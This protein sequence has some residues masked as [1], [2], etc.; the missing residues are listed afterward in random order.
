MALTNRV[1]YVALC[2]TH[3]CTHTLTD[4]VKYYYSISKR[5]CPLN[6]RNQSVALKEYKFQQVEGIWM[7]KGK[8]V[9]FDI[10]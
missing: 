4:L 8:E 1:Q 10:K 2:N 6:V 7:S 9:P 3:G 5:N